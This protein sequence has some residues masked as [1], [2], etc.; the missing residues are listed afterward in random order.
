MK[1]KEFAA[2]VKESGIIDGTVTY[3][4]FGDI[5]GPLKGIILRD[6]TTRMI[7]TQDAATYT[8]D[9][10][11]FAQGDRLIGQGSFRSDDG[12]CSGGWSSV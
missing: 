8:M 2:Q 5:T 4:F 11:V 6:G 7:T 10:K 12:E 3:H 9:G 1:S